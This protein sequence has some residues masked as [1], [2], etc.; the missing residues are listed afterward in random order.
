MEREKVFDCFSK[1]YMYADAR[2]GMAP[3]NLAAR[4]NHENLHAL[5]FNQWLQQPD[6]ANPCY[7][8][9]NYKEFLT[10]H[11]QQEKERNQQWKQEQSLH[12][13]QVGFEEP[14]G[15]SSPIGNPKEGLTHKQQILFLK[16]IG[17]FDLPA[18]KELSLTHQGILTGA[19]LNRDRHNTEDYIR[20]AGG[21]KNVP[22]KFQLG[23]APN[24]KAVNEVL[25]KAELNNLI[26][27]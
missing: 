24:K 5:L 6:R 2:L 9:E 15:E 4:A 14:E 22:A 8:F 21:H 26:M 1:L 23:T 12:R 19:L 27:K 11:L 18:V 7:T 10:Q 16:Q 25:K 20:Y 17:F 13:Q 3:T